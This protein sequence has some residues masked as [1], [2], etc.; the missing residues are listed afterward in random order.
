MERHSITSVDRARELLARGAVREDA[1]V[2][3]AEY[4]ASDVRDLSGPTIVA[5]RALDLSGSLDVYAWEIMQQRVDALFQ[6]VW[7]YFDRVLIVGADAR[8][9]ATKWDDEE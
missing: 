6:R 7:H 8:D 9:F 1:R 3:A 5:G 2:F 4:R